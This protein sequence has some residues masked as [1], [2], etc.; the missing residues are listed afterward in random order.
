MIQIRVWDHG[1]IRQRGWHV[2]INFI[3]FMSEV[4]GTKVINN[5]VGN[6]ADVQ[7]QK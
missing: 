1:Y 7:L 2:L 6:K 4:R 3:N 5:Q